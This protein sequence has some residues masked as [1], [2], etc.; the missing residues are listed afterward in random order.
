[1]PLGGSYRALC[2]RGRIA[3]Q[4]I[5]QLGGRSHHCL[6]QRF[7]LFGRQARGWARNAHRGEASAFVTPE[8]IARNGKLPINT[9]G[10]HTSESYMQ[11]WGLLAEDVRQIRGEAG[12]LQVANCE[13]AM[14]ANA[15]PISN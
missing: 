14:Y 7:E 6:R 3:R 12:P 10:G 13:T 11:G 8:L 9:S 2:G 4:R 1:M 5:R 15:A